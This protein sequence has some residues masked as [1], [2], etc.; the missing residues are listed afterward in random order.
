M[1]TYYVTNQ[2]NENNGDRTA[3]AAAWIAANCPSFVE[4]QISN[5]QRTSVTKFTDN[6][7]ANAWINY[8]LNTMSP[9]AASSHITQTDP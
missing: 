1:P 7:E 5:A 9:P 2:Y 3:A 4:R 6:N 8:S